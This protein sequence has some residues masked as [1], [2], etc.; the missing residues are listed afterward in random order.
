MD[1]RSITGRELR[2]L[3]I[4]AAVGFLTL[5]GAVAMLPL[6]GYVAVGGICVLVVLAAF[7]T[8]SILGFLFG[9][10]R[11]FSDDAQAA[12]AAKPAGS[13]VEPTG[14]RLLKSNA[15]LERVSDW[16]TTMIVGVALTQVLNIGEG[17]AQFQE[18]LRGF[19]AKCDG[20]ISCPTDALVTAGPI[21]LI[22]GVGVGFLFM[23][24]YTR[25]VLTA[26]FNSVEGGLENLSREASAN[27]LSFQ[28]PRAGRVAAAKP[29]DHPAMSVEAA[30]QMMFAALYED[31]PAGFTKA[32]NIAGVLSNSNATTR[33]D[34]WFY[35][36]AA[37]GQQLNHLVDPE[38]K[39]DEDKP[40]PVLSSDARSAL[41]NAI[42]AAQ[43]AIRIDPAYKVRLANI[44]QSTGV[45]TDL[46]L[47]RRDS[48]WSGIMN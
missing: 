44:S 12:K 29:M 35:Q 31:E 7:A 33:A 11:V 38:S 27:V 4:L 23:Y 14:R 20:Q 41:D 46:R 42:D 32:L 10:P 47:V 9:L 39:L 2:D 45:E 6:G 8:G 3:A 30:L 37:F 18:F 25:L 19:S 28:A 1:R 17:L 26:V 15:N 21:L 40:L 5:L 36:A 34:Y 43:R 48:R 13:A 22:A 24:L 16:L